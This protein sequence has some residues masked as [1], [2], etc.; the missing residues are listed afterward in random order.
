MNGLK[1]IITKFSFF[2]TL[3]TL[4]SLYIKFLK[5]YYILIFKSGKKFKPSNFETKNTNNEINKN[6]FTILKDF[7]DQNSLIKIRKKFDKQINILSIVNII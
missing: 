2:Q 7:F 4:I 1:S 3:K 5:Y 6:G